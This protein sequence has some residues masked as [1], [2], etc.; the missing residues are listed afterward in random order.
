MIDQEIET[1]MMLS[2]KHYQEWIEF[3]N[4]KDSPRKWLMGAFATMRALIRIPHDGG[5]PELTR[6]LL[7]LLEK[8]IQEFK[9]SLQQ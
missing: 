2:Y 4:K 9:K 3:D 6:E 8:D 7:E 1:I 5:R